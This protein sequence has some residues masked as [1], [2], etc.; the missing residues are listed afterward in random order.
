[1]DTLDTNGKIC[2]NWTNGGMIGRASIQGASEA[3]TKKTRGRSNECH[4]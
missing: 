2:G 4:R 1:M 3:W